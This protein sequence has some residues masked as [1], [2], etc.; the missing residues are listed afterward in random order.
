MNELILRFKNSKKL[1]LAVIAVLCAVAVMIYFIPPKSNNKENTNISNNTE[2]DATQKLEKVL[3][4][5]KGAGN[6]NV[7]ITYVSGSEAVCANTVEKQTNTVTEK[8]ENGGSKE[9]ETVIENSKPVTVGSGNGENA[10]V[11]VKKEPEI[12]GVIVVAQG[13]DSI[14]VRMDLQKAV[15]TV[16]QVSPE[17]VEIFVMD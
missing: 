13:A 12:K 2:A 3:S 4:S 10:L 11:V 7:M 1:K 15:E 14:K 9:S 16:L 17:K 8:S 5:I 6:V